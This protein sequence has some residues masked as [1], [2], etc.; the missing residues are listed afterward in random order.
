ME[1]GISPVILC[2]WERRCPG[3]RPTVI[4][5]RRW[6]EKM[7]PMTPEIKRLV[8]KILSHTEVE[9]KSDASD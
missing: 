1:I 9:E 8:F 4:S 3:R 2:R 7:S 6:I 5:L